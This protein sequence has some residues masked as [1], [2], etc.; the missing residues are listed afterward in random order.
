MCAHI[1]GV[2]T[3]AQPWLCCAHETPQT[4]DPGG[5]AV[6]TGMDAALAAVVA[7]HPDATIRQNPETGRWEAIEFPTETCEQL[8]TAPTLAELD[9][10]LSGDAP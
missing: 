8:T 6:D 2:V 9:I 5:V 7:R 4:H 3:C 1:Q 10:K